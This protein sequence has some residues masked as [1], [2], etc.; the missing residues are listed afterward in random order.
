MKR[1]GTLVVLVVVGF[2]VVSEAFP[3]RRGGSSGRGIFGTI[4]G[5]KYKAKN[6]GT[7][8]DLCAN[9]IYNPALKILTFGG[10]ECKKRHRLKKNYRVVVLSCAHFDQRV[11]P[12]SLT[13]PFELPCPNSAY[14]EYK[15]GRFG[16]IK[17]SATWLSTFFLDENIFPS[18]HLFV[19]VDAFDGTN[20]RGAFF[21]T[22]DTP[23]DGATSPAAPVNGEV[24]FNFPFVIH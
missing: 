6:D 14:T 19:R 20:V 9:G 10:V 1:A 17:S 22:F 4:N 15:T 3:A 21:G 16:E 23:G 5:R 13:P 18:S 11:D 2:G 12:A 8:T 7:A 24:Q